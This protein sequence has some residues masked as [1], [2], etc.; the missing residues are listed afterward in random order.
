MCFKVLSSFGGHSF[1][2]LP[3]SFK[4]LAFS[5]TVEHEAKITNANITI[6]TLSKNIESFYFT[7]GVA[8]TDIYIKID[9][10]ISILKYDTDTRKD[11]DGFL[12][13]L[14]KLIKL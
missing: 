14:A 6:L 8:V 5:F 4:P 9:D 2:I 11:E 3:I 13:R 10:T 7:S 1:V 12:G